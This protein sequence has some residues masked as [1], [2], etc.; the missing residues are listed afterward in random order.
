MLRKLNSVAK[1]LILVSRVA[2]IIYPF[3]KFLLFLYNLS[4]LTVWINRN[5]NKTDQTDFFRLTRNYHERLNGFAFIADKYQLQGNPVSYFE[6]GVASGVSFE[7][8]LQHAKHADSKFFGFDTFEGL[9]EDWGLFF[10]KGAMAHD[11]KAI[12]DERHH[13][14][15]GI[16]QDTMRNF[17]NEHRSTL[18]LE[19]RKV[20]LFDADLFSS[21]IYVLTQ[22]YPYLRKGDVLIFDE[23][24]VPSHEFYAMKI[25]RDCFYVKLRP[26]SAINNFYQTA[27]EIEKI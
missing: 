11:M 27:F 23:F 3:R 18:E 4:E 21:T 22:L 19:R 5:K 7:W 26:V 16:F 9:P 13:F 15:K 17:V 8:W 25:F 2:Y 10:K 20:L 1:D 6:F 14:V 12:T 24:N